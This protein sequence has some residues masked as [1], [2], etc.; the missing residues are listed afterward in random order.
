M[1][2]KPGREGQRKSAPALGFELATGRRPGIGCTRRRRSVVGQVDPGVIAMKLVF[3][4]CSLALL[5]AGPA[6]APVGDAVIRG[7]AGPSEIVI[8]TTARVAG[9]IDS[10]TWNGREFLDSSDHGRQLQSAS[11]LDCGKQFIPEVFNPTEAGSVADGA[12]PTSSSVLLSLRAGKN[13]LETTTRMAFWLPPGGKSEGHPAYNDTVVSDHLLTKR[14]RIGARGLPHAIEYEVSFTLPKGEH[15]RLAQFE[16]LT[17]YMPP[18]FRDFWAL[19][20][21]TGTLSPLSDGPGEQAKPVILATPNGS[22]AMGVY[23]PEQPPPGYGRF[24]F[25]AAKV[26]K[27]NCVF[28]VR[29]PAGVAPGPYRYRMFVAVGTLDDV[30]R[31]L[32]TLA[33]ES[34]VKDGK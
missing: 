27:W 4:A 30:R 10:L 7:R 23:S 33:R 20:V 32:T 15:H 6:A 9:A 24:R 16:A 8:K 29:D 3:L 11:N 22:H 12:G 14:V 31:T 5:G 1:M 18:A 21:G 26:N 28:R 19:D 2:K 13:T 25:E 34:G 17:G